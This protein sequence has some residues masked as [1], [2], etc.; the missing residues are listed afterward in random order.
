MTEEPDPLEHADVGETKTIFREVTLDSFNLEPEVFWGIDRIGESEIVDA[1]IIDGE[2]SQEIRLTWEADV[3]KTVPRNWDY[4]REPLT[5][6]EE[7][8][9]KRR[10]WLVYAVKAIPF[11]I[12]GGLTVLSVYIFNQLANGVTINGEPLAP[13]DLWTTTLVFILTAVML[14]ALSALVPKGGSVY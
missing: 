3:T 9:E 13:A 8:R 12:A 6:K 4:C 7:R 2:D 5:E 1:E 10:S 14:Y 11:A